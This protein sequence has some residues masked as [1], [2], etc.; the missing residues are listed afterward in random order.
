LLDKQLPR[1]K[2]LKQ[3]YKAWILAAALLL[4]SAAFALTDEEQ[5]E[6]MSAVTEGNVAVVTKYLDSGVVKVN[7]TFFAWS[8]LLSA[9][10]KGQLEVVKVLA[11][12][13]ADLNYKHPL[14]KMTAVAHAAYDGNTVLLEYLLQKGADPNIKARGGVSTIRLA[15]GEGHEDCV[16]ILLK[17]GAKDD[18]CQEEKCF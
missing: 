13:G 3:K 12:R 15:R 14:T 9:A 2:Q 1:R 6:F 11:E 7:D 8:P 18:G 5:I 16:V 17:Y 10:S 4:P